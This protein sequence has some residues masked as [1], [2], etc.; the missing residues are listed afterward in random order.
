MKPGPK[1]LAKKYRRT[2]RLQ[3]QLNQAEI[4][5]A[6]RL[7][8]SKGITVPELFRAYLHAAGGDPTLLVNIL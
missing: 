6:R 4:A 5:L 7:A 1:R 8:K 3:V 2:H